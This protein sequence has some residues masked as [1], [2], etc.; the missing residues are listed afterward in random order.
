MSYSMI[1]NRLSLSDIFMKRTYK[2]H[3]NKCMDCI[4]FFESEECAYQFHL[5]SNIKENYEMNG[6]AITK[7][8]IL[9]EFNFQLLGSIFSIEIGMFIDDFN[10]DVKSIKFKSEN[11]EEFYIINCND[12]F[13]EPTLR[14]WNYGN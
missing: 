10:W 12:D 11:S 1:F 5:Y 8:S 4:I 7:I 2:I 14:L 6:I 3:F 13:P 9:P